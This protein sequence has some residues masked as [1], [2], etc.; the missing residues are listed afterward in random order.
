MIT[1]AING[2]LYVHVYKLIN[3]YYLRS[4]K[5]SWT[6]EA[7]QEVGKKDHFTITVISPSGEPMEPTKVA[8]IFRN[9]CGVMVRDRIPISVREWNKSK[10]VPQSEFIADRFKG[11]LFYDLMAHFTLPELETQIEM[12]KQRE[13]VKKWAL[14]KMGELFRQW[15]KRLWATYKKDKKA[16][17]FEGYLAKQD[18]NRDAF[19]EYKT[20]EDAEAL[21]KKNKKNADEKVYHHKT[22]RGGYK[23]AMPKWAEQEAEML[24]NG[25]T[26]EPIR[27][28]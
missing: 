9:Q 24:R 19:V 2:I 17:N 4:P 6:N 1:R 16:P 20:S 14:M 27:E 7:R 22:G 15:K 28:N 8:T 26:P 10:K 25:V 13:K 12:D 3:V 18:H 5:I 21:S 11:N 23:K